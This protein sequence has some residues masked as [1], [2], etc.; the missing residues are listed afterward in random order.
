MLLKSFQIT[1]NGG[2][3]LKIAPHR[4][5]KVLSTF[6]PP[7]AQTLLPNTDWFPHA[8]LKMCKHQ[9]TEASQEDLHPPVAP[10]NYTFSFKMRPKSL[11]QIPPGVGQSW[12]GMVTGK[13]ELGF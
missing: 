4:A 13:G 3:T 5:R 7:K 1:N 12:H 10:L 2:Q 8:P 6:K 11:H 9:R